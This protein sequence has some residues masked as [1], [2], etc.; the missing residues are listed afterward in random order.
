MVNLLPFLIMP[1][2]LFPCCRRRWR[3]D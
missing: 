3:M 2:T 1:L